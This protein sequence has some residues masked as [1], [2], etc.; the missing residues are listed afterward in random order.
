MREEHINKYHESYNKLQ[1]PKPPFCPGDWVLR[2]LPREDR[3]KLS[4]H[5]DGPF[6]V[7]KQLTPPNLEPGKGNVY[8]VSDHEGNEFVRSIVDL[9]PYNRSKDDWE[10]FREP[11]DVVDEVLEGPPQKMEVKSSDVTWDP[12]E[13]ELLFG[14]DDDTS[15]V[16]PLMNQLRPPSSA[17]GFAGGGGHT[18][19]ADLA[20]PVQVLV[21]DNNN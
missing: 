11:E 8:L 20:D 18:Q 2:R 12:V 3:A 21:A 15:G 13:F 17:S 4:L 16:G 1:V 9:K 6:I 14:S 10:A 5:W 19:H 7:M